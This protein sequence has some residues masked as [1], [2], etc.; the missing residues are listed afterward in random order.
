VFS[1]RD[2]L[3]H[4]GYLF[5]FCYV[6]AVQAGV[7]I[8]ADPLL[9]IMGALI[10]SHLYGFWPSLALA[11]AAALI[12][13]AIWFELGRA[14]GRSVLGFVCKFSL[15]PDTCVRKTEA[16]FARRGAGALLFAK[17]IPG[18]GLVAMPLSGLIRMPRF[19]FFLFDAAGVTLWALVYLFLGFIFHREVD[20]LIIALGLLGRRAGLIVAILIGGYLAFKYI[21]R[22]R[23]LR[24]LRINRIS[25]EA[26][27]NMLESGRRVTVVDLRH[28]A[29]VEREGI[30][31]YGAVL[32]PPGELP[33]RSAQIPKD[34]EIVLY[35]TC[36]NE[37]TS[38][39]VA[40]LLR[41]Q[42]IRHVRPL[43]GGLQAWHESGFPV[44]PV[45]T[46][47]QESVSAK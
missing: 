47:G 45:T 6:L 12:G 10:G 35:C 27:N 8:P 19:R 33:A 38:A 46:T 16:S 23:F 29:E 24:Q 14:R 7:P 20:A 25:P 28:P 22:R 43:S 18:M 11:A 32:I 9:L 26:L 5:L 13:D 37:A 42:G 31:I 4:H 41:R 39:R 2:L 44:E 1:I 34:H 40:L 3:L 17:F 30:K 36:P 15:E 21:Q